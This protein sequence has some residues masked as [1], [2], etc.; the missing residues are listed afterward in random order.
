MSCLCSYIL[1]LS[2]TFH[3]NLKFPPSIAAASSMVLAIYCLR[4][5]DTHSLWPDELANVTGLELN[6][7]LAECSVRLSQDIET[8]R[9]TTHRLD[10]IHKRHSK[11][12]RHNVADIAIPILTSTTTLAA[13]EELVRSRRGIPTSNTRRT[14]DQNNPLSLST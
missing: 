12:C 1:E 3:T 11:P 6:K 10:M 8:A 14:I 4:N 9:H 2:L 7:D 13:Y 5:D